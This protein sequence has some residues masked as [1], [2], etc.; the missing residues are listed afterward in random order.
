MHG[1]PFTNWYNHGTSVT[2]PSGYTTRDV[3]FGFWI[4]QSRPPG[5]CVPGPRPRPATRTAAAR[6]TRP[7]ILEFP[8]A[9]TA[10][11]NRPP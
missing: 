5:R 1:T 9:H 8:L 2:P 4:G 7:E 11:I 6:P 3:A 10:G